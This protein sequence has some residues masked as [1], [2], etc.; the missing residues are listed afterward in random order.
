M[1]SLCLFRLISENIVQVYYDFHERKVTYE[2]IFFFNQCYCTYYSN[3]FFYLK[4][5]R[6]I[7]KIYIHYTYLDKVHLFGFI[8]VKKCVFTTTRIDI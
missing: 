1:L 6:Y 2:Y 5:H 4:K 8:K 3:L 7:F